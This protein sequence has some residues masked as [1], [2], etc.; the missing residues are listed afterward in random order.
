ML[1]WNWTHFSQGHHLNQPWLAE[2]SHKKATYFNTI[3][4]EGM[5]ALVLPFAGERLGFCKGSLF[6]DT[7][8]SFSVPLELKHQVVMGNHSN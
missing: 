7:S 5:A 1:S 4:V 2:P 3:G 8:V 6:V